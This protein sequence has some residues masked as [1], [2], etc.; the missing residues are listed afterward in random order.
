MKPTTNYTKFISMK[1]VLKLPILVAFLFLFSLSIHAQKKGYHALGA[2]VLFMDYGYVNGVDSLDITN[3]FE[4]QYIRNFN[5]YVSFALPVKVGVADVVGDLENRTVVSVDALVH[6]QYE[7]DSSFLIPY[8]LGGVGFVNEDFEENNINVPLGVGLNLK[9]S[10]NA[11][12]NIQG[13]YRLAFEDNRTNAQLG[14]GL[15]YRLRTQDADN[16]GIPDSKDQCPDA[17]GTAATDG[18]P[19]FDLDGIRD[20]RDKCP[21]LP[22]KRAMNGCP[23]TDGDGLTDDVDPCP[24]QAGEQNGCPDKDGDGVLDN[25]DQCPEIAGVKALAG[26]PDADG[27][28]VTDAEDK[29]PNEKGTLV[30]QGCP[31]QDNDGII[32]RDDK[33]PT[34]AGVP[35]A[36]G[37]P[38]ADGDGIADAEDRCPN[39]AGDS[40]GCPDTDG[41]GIDDGDDRCPEIAGIAANKGCPEIKKEEKEA[42]EFAAQAV[43]FETGK[44]T[45][46]R[47]SN[48]ILDQ[49]VDILKK[50]PGYKLRISGH[51]DNTG[52]ADRNLELSQERAA[53]CYNYLI[54]NGIDASRMM[55]EGF[56]ESKP[57]ADNRRSRGRKLNRRVE[58]DLYID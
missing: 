33:C 44:A 48:K 49:I 25:D 16:D 45:L 19:D 40:N 30:T 24:E 12:I 22:G 14:V 46:K 11:L 47:A 29:C 54:S 5:P 3:G 38:D 43:Q 53:A 13:E 1:T 28:G 37:C 31:D 23:D 58:F 10:E 7:K 34:E 42:L 35:S 26:C 4:L 15:I 8:L 55:Y 21:K 18:C 20:T 27:D 32:D 56:G 52:D 2:K 36:A 17:P 39:K 51:T 57:I 6:L 50:Y 41:D 9:L